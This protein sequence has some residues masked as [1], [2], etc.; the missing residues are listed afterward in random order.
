MTLAD[1]LHLE[2]T[3]PDCRQTTTCK[4]MKGEEGS[5]G[6]TGSLLGCSKWKKSGGSGNC[7]EEGVLV[8]KEGITMSV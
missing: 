8:G 2:K 6:Y 4:C 5:D 3:V 1:I 7:L